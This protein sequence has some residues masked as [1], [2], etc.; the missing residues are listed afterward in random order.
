MN[1]EENAE[2]VENLSFTNEEK[3]LLFGIARESIASVLEKKKMAETDEKNVLPNLQRRLGAFVTLKIDG[4]L[5]GCVGRFPSSEPLFKVVAMSA[6]SSA[7]EDSRFT[8]LTKEEFGRL[9][10]EITVLGPL[11]KISDISEIVL[12][13]HGVVV[14][15]DSGSG[16]LLPQVAIE[17]GWNVEQFL[18]Y[19]SR[20]KAGLGWNGWKDA[21]VSIYEGIVLRE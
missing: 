6:V 10:I 1:I 2:S 18:G 15:K 16:T 11:K 5:R 21:E 9:N 13:T 14:R 3:K 7:F 20:D 12:G 8:V 17:H 4:K 19:T